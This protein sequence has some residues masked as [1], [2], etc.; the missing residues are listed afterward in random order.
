MVS[1]L[2]AGAC[3]GGDRGSDV[4]GVLGAL[5]LEIKGV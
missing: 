3:G 1:T 4:C 5:G 2:M